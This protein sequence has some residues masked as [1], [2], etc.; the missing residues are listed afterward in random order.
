MDD[1][2]RLTVFLT[3]LSD[4][5]AV[6]EVSRS[7]FPLYVPTRTTVGVAAL[8]KGALSRSRPCSPTARAPSRTPRRPATS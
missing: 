1:V 2:V 7:Y 8:P 6:N 4:L 5:D 3:D